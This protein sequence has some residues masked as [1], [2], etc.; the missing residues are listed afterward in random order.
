M[1]E[2][3]EIS[4]LLSGRKTLLIFTRWEER[5]HC[6]VIPHS[7]LDTTLHTYIHLHACP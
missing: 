7:L 1:T 5:D 6:K 3:D 4:L 2:F